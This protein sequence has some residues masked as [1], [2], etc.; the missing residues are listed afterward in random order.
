[1]INVCLKVKYSGDPNSR[2]SN[3]GYIKK[4]DEL[5][6]GYHMAIAIQKQDKLSGFQMVGR[7]FYLKTGPN[8]FYTSLDRF[9][10]K[11]L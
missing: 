1:M 9:I 8:S 2:H 5:G 6:S 11:N 10:T 7:H 4:P 3:S